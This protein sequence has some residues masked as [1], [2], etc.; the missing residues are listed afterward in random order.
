M[1]VKTEKEQQWSQKC[2]IDTLQLLVR[3][4]FVCNLCS[5][6]T[7]HFFWILSGHTKGSSSE[8]I[9]ASSVPDAVG[10]ILVD[11][12]IT[13]SNNSKF[14]FST[15]P[16]KVYIKSHIQHGLLSCVC[17]KQTSSMLKMW[18]CFF[19]CSPS[20]YTL[21]TLLQ[22]SCPQ[23]FPVKS[24]VRFESFLL[25]EIIHSPWT[26]HHGATIGRS[27]FSSVCYLMSMQRLHS[28]I[29]PITNTFMMSASFHFDTDV[30]LRMNFSFH[31]F[32]LS[33]KEI[34]FFINGEPNCESDHLHC[35]QVCV[36]LWPVERV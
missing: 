12:D 17:S 32:D 24:S 21:K 19:D 31:E 5:Q 36:S 13:I 20:C 3:T 35:T 34:V 28:S 27:K 8:L 1:F 30:A 33:W 29:T 23:L 18:G 15:K 6:P 7:T 16:W 9:T 26:K 2:N 4:F 22:R 10:P 25:S 11:P 14:N